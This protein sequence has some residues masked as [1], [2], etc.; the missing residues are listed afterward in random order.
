[1]SLRPRRVDV[2]DDADF[3]SGRM[4]PGRGRWSESP[5]P[6]PAVRRVRAGAAPVVSGDEAFSVSWG[7]TDWDT[8]EAVTSVAFVLGFAP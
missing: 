6:R 5:V 1:M 8:P 2:M 4:T 3:A 7:G